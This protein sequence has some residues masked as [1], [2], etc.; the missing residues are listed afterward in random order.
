MREF[1]GWMLLLSKREETKSQAVS[2]LGLGERKTGFNQ[3][4]SF[5]TSHLEINWEAGKNN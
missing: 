3:M 5:L 1:S 4:V 2:S